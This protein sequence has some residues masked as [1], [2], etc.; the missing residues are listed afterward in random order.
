MRT[1][2]FFRSLLCFASLLTALVKP[3]HAAITIDTVTVGNPGNAEDPFTNFGAVSY[4]YNIGTYEVT[5]GQYAAF[6]NAVAAT[7]TFGLYNPAM[8]SD[9]H[10]AGIS[11][12]GVSGSFSYSVIGSAL[13]PIT[14]VSWGDAGALLQ[15]AIQRPARTW[16]SSR[17]AE[18]CFHRRRL[19]HAQRRDHSRS[20]E[21]RHAESRRNL[22]HP[23]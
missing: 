13:K 3:A 17:A 19:L 15:L 11:Q 16:R 6:L 21:L 1:S 5:V 22:G 8:T 23:N 18:R 9:L 10:S 4:T 12:S 7:D 20:L 2:R 14:Y